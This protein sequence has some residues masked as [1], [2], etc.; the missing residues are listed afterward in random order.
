MI[1]DITVPYVAPPRKDGHAQFG[2]ITQRDAEVL[3]RMGT[4]SSPGIP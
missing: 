3:R 2:T 1:H 4:G